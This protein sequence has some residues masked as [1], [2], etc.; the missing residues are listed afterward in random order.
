[1]Q[2]VMVLGAGTMG[3]GIAQVVAQG[4]CQV[5]L[6]DIKQEFVDRGLNTISKNLDRLVSKGKMAAEEKEAVLGRIMPALELSSGQDA[7]L[8]IEAVIENMDLKKEVFGQLDEICSPATI[9]ASNTSALSISELAASTKRPDKV[10]GMHFFNP[11]PVMQLVEITKGAATSEEVYQTIYQF[12]RDLGKEPVSVNEAPGFIVNRMLVPMINEAV[13]TLMEGVATAE[14]IDKGMRLGA[15]HPIGPLALADMIGLD[16][17]LAVM[18]TLWQ[19]FG[20]SKYRPCPLLRK[21][22]RAGY[23]GR[24]AGRGFYTYQ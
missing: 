17:C 24:K 19:E 20:D 22:V 14:D 4:G 18:E 8:V 2:K 10:I 13:Y 3:A 7:D 5:I 9:F 1:M 15:N 16:V 21:M 6:R 11:V 12:A 23:L